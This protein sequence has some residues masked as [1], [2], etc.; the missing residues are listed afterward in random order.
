MTVA[1]PFFSPFHRKKAARHAE[2]HVII[3]RSDFPARRPTAWYPTRIVVN[4]LTFAQHIHQV[5]QPIMN[6][7]RVARAAV[8]ARPAALRAVAQ[9]RTYAEA[10]PDKVEFPSVKPLP[11]WSREA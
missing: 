3:Q 10:V 4:E 9:R 6:T 2:Y 5:S 11:L 1:N 7:F 8:R